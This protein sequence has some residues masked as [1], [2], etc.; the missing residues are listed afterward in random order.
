MI[1][2]SARWWGGSFSA[3]EEK[4][5]MMKVSIEEEEENQFYF[6][7]SWSFSPLW[8]P[9]LPPLFGRRKKKHNHGNKRS[10]HEITWKQTEQKLYAETNQYII[11]LFFFFGFST[12]HTSSWEIEPSSSVWRRVSAAAA[13]T[14]QRENHFWTQTRMR[15]EGYGITNKRSNQSSACNNNNNM[16]VDGSLFF[17]VPIASREIICDCVNR[18]IG[19]PWLMRSGRGG[20]RRRVGASKRRKHTQMRL[21]TDYVW[22]SENGTRSFFCLSSR[23]RT[24]RTRGWVSFPFPSWPFGCCCCLLLLLLFLLCVIFPSC[25]L[26]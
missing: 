10:T 18:V 20:G 9:R 4:K 3:A 7:G 26:L 12:G 5:K 2:Y 15:W 1:D 8:A 19:T 21:S 14:D 24:R 13:A 6:T 11:F 23:N 16:A 17:R 22:S 25:L